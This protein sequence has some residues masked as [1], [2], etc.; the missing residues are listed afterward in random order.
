MPTIS[1]ACLMR[2]VTS[3]SASEGSTPAL[4]VIVGQDDAGGAVG[5]GVGKDLARVDGGAVE[6]ADGDDADVHDFVGAVDGDAQEMLLL[7]VGEVADEGQDIGRGGD[8]EPSGFDAAARKFDGGDDDHRL[9]VAHAFE[10]F[11][12]LD[13]EVQALG[14][15]GLNQVF[16]EGHDIYSGGTFAEQDG[17]QLVVFEG[18][19]A[20]GAEF[21]AWAVVL[22]DGVERAIHTA[23]ARWVS[24]TVTA[25]M[26]KMPPASV[27][28]GSANSS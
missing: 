4:G 24:M 27:Y 8:L 7:A 6:Q 18:G 21:L 9:D 14:V 15:N 1:P 23:K 25:M 11:E 5:D 26:S 22:G 20:S 10:V 16:G 2:R 13:L 28:F 3:A 19:G 12:V 17:Q